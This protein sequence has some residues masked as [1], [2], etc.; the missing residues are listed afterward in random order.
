MAQK[1]YKRNL[2][3]DYFGDKLAC[4]LE[5]AGF[6]LKPVRGA[7]INPKLERV[8]AEF[9]LKGESAHV[10]AGK[11]ELVYGLAA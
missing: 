8:V 4:A 7:R 6:S 3:S 5:Q 9:L 1:D 11:S 2:S 10:T